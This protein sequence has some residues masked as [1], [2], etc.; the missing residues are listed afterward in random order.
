MHRLFDMIKLYLDTLDRQR[1]AI[2][3]QL[4]SF[5]DAWVL[6]GGTALALQLGHRKSFDFDLFSPS[7]IVRTLYRQVC[8][9]FNESPVKLV[10][11]GDQLTLAMSSGTECTFLYYWYPAQ[12]SVISTPSL[13]LFDKRDIAADKAMT[14]GRRN[15]WRDYVD[16]YVILKYKHM[17]LA[18][19]ISVAQKKFNNEFS[20]KLFLEELSYTDDVRDT[21]AEWT[22]GA[23][24]RKEITDFLE[25]E[26]I[27]YGKRMTL[28]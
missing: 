16:L 21:S 19:L 8:T 6:G 11:T 27:A 9:V 3:T 12:F 5:K 2:F 28:L 17:T 20:P 25:Q 18:E 1:Q 26:A 7:P 24:D 15:V 23:V 13:S 14:L 22:S 10:D 4:Q